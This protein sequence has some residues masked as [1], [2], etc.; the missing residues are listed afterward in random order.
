M[1]QNGLEV[2]NLCECFDVFIDRGRYQNTVRGVS[3]LSIDVGVYLGVQANANQVSGVM[4]EAIG[5]V[6]YLLK[7]PNSENV[8]TGGFVAGHGGNTTVIKTESSFNPKTN[9]HEG[10]WHNWFSGLLCEPGPGSRYYDFDNYSSANTLIGHDNTYHGGTTHDSSFTYLSAGMLRLGDFNA[11]SAH[12]PKDGPWKP[13][14]GKSTVLQVEGLGYIKNLEHGLPS[15]RIGLIEKRVEA[16]DDEP[17]LLSSNDGG[18]ALSGI[19]ITG[20]A[21][22]VADGGGAAAAACF[23]EITLS[24]FSHAEEEKDGQHDLVKTT[25]VYT[26]RYLATPFR[27]P[28]SDT[29]RVVVKALTPAETTPLGEDAWSVVPTCTASAEPGNAVLIAVEGVQ[30]EGSYELV[31]D[32]RRVGHGCASVSVGRTIDLQLNKSG[33]VQV[34]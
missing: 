9:Q 4:M 10:T 26:G 7:G 20:L 24:G 23:Y 21:A 1:S 17:T 25:R 14:T 28:G 27:L 30:D 22:R 15:R 6:A 31:V 3:I 34:P 2:G 8:L 13:P 19:L 32:T 33:D 5:Q 18:G 29:A 12:Q 11:S 16:V